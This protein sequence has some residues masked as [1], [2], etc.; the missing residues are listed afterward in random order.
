MAAQIREVAPDLYEIWYQVDLKG[1]GSC[2]CAGWAMR[3]HCRHLDQAREYEGNLKQ[4][5]KEGLVKRYA[6]P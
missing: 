5:E 3:A 4:M 2:S 1:K 6:K